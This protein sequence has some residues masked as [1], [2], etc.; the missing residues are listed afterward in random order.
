MIR[1]PKEQKVLKK[2]NLELKTISIL[3]SPSIEKKQT[4]SLY[5]F[6]HTILLKKIFLAS[7]IL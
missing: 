6:F 3:I 4:Y 7:I 5:N 2:K 1:C